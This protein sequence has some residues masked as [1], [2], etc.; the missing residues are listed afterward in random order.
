M[1]KKIF[2]KFIACYQIVGGVFLLLG[3]MLFSLDDLLHVVICLIICLINIFVGIVV[4]SE[5]RFGIEASII[6]FIFQIP[7]LGCFDGINYDY[8]LLCQIKCLFFVNQMEQ[9]ASFE[10]MPNFILNF[11]TCSNCI[12]G[13][14]IVPL[15]LIIGIL[16]AS[17]NEDKESFLSLGD[18]SVN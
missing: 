12:V 3:A 9:I 14:N 5:E 8:N 7:F 16:R 6:N 18:G 10:F 13:V 17:S 4:L 15:L 1:E 11:E 2:N